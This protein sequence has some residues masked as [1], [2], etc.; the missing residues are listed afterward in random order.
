MA[1]GIIA[2]ILNFV[3]SKAPTISILVSHIYKN[4]WIKCITINMIS[5]ILLTLRCVKGNWSD[6]LTEVQLGTVSQLTP[7]PRQVE[8]TLQN[9]ELVPL[10]QPA[11]SCPGST[12]HGRTLQGHPQCC[13]QKDLPR[14]QQP[15]I[16]QAKPAKTINLAISYNVS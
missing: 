14:C 16:Y 10:A 8:Q 6:F 3:Y 2:V 1:G 12:P 15:S 9:E 4:I 13:P 11:F 7:C 5:Y